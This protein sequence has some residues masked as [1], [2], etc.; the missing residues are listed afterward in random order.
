VTAAQT[1]IRRRKAE[2][3]P[4]PSPVNWRWMVVAAWMAGALVAAAGLVAAVL[5][6]VRSPMWT[7]RHIELVGD[8]RRNS[9]ATLRANSLPR[10]S[11]TFFTMD[12]HQTREVFES[13]PWVRQAV[14][15]RVF[16]DRLVVRLQE[17]QPA[18]RWMG[19]DGNERLVN[20]FGEVFDANLG[21]VEGDPLPIFSGPEGRA[22]EVL[23]MYQ[24]LTAVFTP[25]DRRI[26]RLDV[27]GRGSW[28]LLLDDETEVTIGRGTAQE[29]VARTERFVGTV[30]QVTSAYK[31][32]L[33]QADLRHN[34]GYAVRLKGVV[35]IEPSAKKG[36]K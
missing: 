21:E 35:S 26:A 32:A 31:T 11:G 30:T 22:H 13:V 2:T 29:V 16:P 23:Q 34:N 14:V 17:H 18:A 19:H 7:I 8:V 10:L 28:G 27:S 20:T 12:L 33:L 24:K 1:L 5:W 25:L 36:G 4:P 9:P 15:R 3:K 6:F